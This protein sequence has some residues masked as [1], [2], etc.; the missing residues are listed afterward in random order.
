[1][2]IFQYE[3]LPTREHT[4]V[5]VLEPGPRC[6]ITSPLVGSLRLLDL[7]DAN[8]EPFE[9]ISY[10]W[11][12]PA[13]THVI[14]VD[15]HPLPMTASLRDALL[16]TRLPDQSRTLWADAICINQSDHA[17]K[18]HQVAVMARIYKASRRTLICLGVQNPTQAQT[19][20]FWIEEVNLVLENVSRSP[21]LSGDAGSFVS[22]GEVEI[23]TTPF[24]PLWSTGWGVM[25]RQ[26]WFQRGWVV[27]EALLGPDACVLW[28]SEQIGWASI[29]RMCYWWVCRGRF[30]QGFIYGPAI[31]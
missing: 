4:R 25:V 6:D 26:T 8:S 29:L 27:Q 18:G 24:D 21:S 11:G 5:L 28:G 7:C 23:D 3:P 15:G 10:V 30:C 16:Q 1:M 19:A 20:A 17:E 14:L 9:A 13:R 2:L 31:A 22:R 12:P